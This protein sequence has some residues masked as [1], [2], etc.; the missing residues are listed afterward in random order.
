MPST[1]QVQFK[2]KC[3]ENQAN[4]DIVF[5]KPYIVFSVIIEDL[6]KNCQRNASVLNGS[7]KNTLKLLEFRGN[8]SKNVAADLG[9][10]TSMKHGYL[11]VAMFTFQNVQV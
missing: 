6:D 5:S 11:D 2:P 10:S 3:S 8:I 9:L 7:L 4:T 1:G